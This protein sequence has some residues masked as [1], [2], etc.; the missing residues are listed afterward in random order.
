MLFKKARTL[1][2]HLELVIL[3]FG[4]LIGYSPVFIFGLGIIELI[5]C[6]R[7]L[8][9]QCVKICIGNIVPNVWLCILLICYIVQVVVGREGEWSRLI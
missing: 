5:K 9:A 2:L 4:F 3:I 6:D 8:L 7:A 1:S